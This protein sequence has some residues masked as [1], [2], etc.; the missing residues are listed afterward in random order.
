MAHDL[1]SKFFFNYMLVLQGVSTYNTGG[2]IS[3]SLSIASVLL[4]LTSR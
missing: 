3:D 2:Y 1:A 4:S